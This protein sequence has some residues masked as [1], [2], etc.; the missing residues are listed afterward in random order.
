MDRCEDVEPHPKTG[1]VYVVCTNNTDRG[2]PG[3]EGA[4][5]AQPARRTTGTGTSSRS[6]RPGTT[7]R[8]RPSAGASCWSAATRRP[9]P[10]PTSRGSRPTRSRPSP[11][12]TTSPSTP[13]AT[14][15]SPPTAP[16]ASSAT[17]TACSRCRSRAPSAAASSSSSPSP[18]TPRP[19]GRWS[20][21][22]DR[23][24][25]VAVQHPGENGTWAQQRSYVPGL[26]RTGLPGRWPVGRAAAERHP[27]LEALTSDRRTAL[28]AVRRSPED[29]GPGRAAS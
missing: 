25:Y 13:R 24:V 29:D 17:A 20:A 23:M 16:P 10:R 27:G 1:R 11:A 12:R 15:G 14:C 6:P 7:P 22:D 19:A 28:G 3:K 4:D 8:R 21:T 9:T 26:R 18:S 2:K 5:R